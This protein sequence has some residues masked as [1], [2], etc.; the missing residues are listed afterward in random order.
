[1]LL[2][3]DKIVTIAIIICFKC[4]KYAPVMICRDI[5]RAI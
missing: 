1:M 3:N 4:L 2:I 5:L